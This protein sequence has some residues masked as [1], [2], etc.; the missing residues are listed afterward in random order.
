MI[1]DMYDET[2]PISLDREGA[3]MIRSLVRPGPPFSGILLDSPAY[4]YQQHAR[5]LREKVNN[6]ILR[7]EDE[8]ETATVDINIGRDEAWLLDQGLQIDGER[9]VGTDLLIQ[10]FRGLWNLDNSY[11]PRKIVAEPTIPSRNIVQDI[12]DTS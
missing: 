1:D 4:K 6:T 3:W 9:G 8:P 2:F 10:I 7:F 11:L 12:I 5:D